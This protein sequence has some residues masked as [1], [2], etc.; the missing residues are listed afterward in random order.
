MGYSRK[1]ST[2]LPHRWVSGI[3]SGGGFNLGYENL[4][5]R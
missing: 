4:V 2:P 3:L 5:G 1:K